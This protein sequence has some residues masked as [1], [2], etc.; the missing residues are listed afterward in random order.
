MHVTFF[1]LRL[2]VMFVFSCRERP[3]TF[4]QTR[5]KHK[6]S[7]RL[8]L[9]IFCFKRSA[10]LRFAFVSQTLHFVVLLFKGLKKVAEQL[11]EA[12]GERLRR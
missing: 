2:K 1:T 3:E 6:R 5:R 4:A 7:A 10:F 8:L 11:P 9:N 12:R